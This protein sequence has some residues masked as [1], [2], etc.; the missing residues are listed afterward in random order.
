MILTPLCYT[1]SLPTVPIAVPSHA[2]LT[3]N[4]G[5][6]IVATATGLTQPLVTPNASPTS[7]ARHIVA[8][9]SGKEFF[10]RGGTDPLVTPRGPLIV[11]E[12]S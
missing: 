4:D 6:D 8:R 9:S 1:R 12:H 2:L 5:D 3:D 7:K 11:G 10:T